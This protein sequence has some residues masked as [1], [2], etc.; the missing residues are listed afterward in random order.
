MDVLHIHKMMIMY[1]I[2]YTSYRIYIDCDLPQ[3]IVQRVRGVVQDG[4]D[5]V[6]HLPLRH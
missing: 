2:L 3:F 6:L 1:S 4:F 5:P